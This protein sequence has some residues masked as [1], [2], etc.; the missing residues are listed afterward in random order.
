MLKAYFKGA[1]AGA[2][3]GEKNLRSR[4]KTDP[5]RNTAQGRGVNVDRMEEGRII[6]PEL[7]EGC[8]R[9]GVETSF[10]RLI[11]MTQ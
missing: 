9:T 2:G 3:A 1:G 8:V 4:F 5:L 6:P 10:K 7:M 11:F